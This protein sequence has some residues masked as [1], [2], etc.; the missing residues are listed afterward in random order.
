MQLPRATRRIRDMWS[1]RMTRIMCLHRMY[2]PSLTTKIPGTPVNLEIILSTSKKKNTKSKVEEGNKQ[3]VPGTTIRADL[4][5]ADSALEEYLALTL[6]NGD[7][8]ISLQAFPEA[9][10]ARTLVD[11]IEKVVYQNPLILGFRGYG[12]DY[13]KLTLNVK[14]DDSAETI[15][16][17][18]KEILTEADKVIAAVIKEGMS[19]DEKQMA[20]YDYLNDNTAYDDA[21]LENAKEQEFKTV[22]AKYNDSFNTY[23]I[24]VKKSAYA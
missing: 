13:E 21:A 24:L 23:G 12:Y 11:V 2:R 9:Q 22:D 19:A 15:R 6:I 7:T 3:A 20:I 16:S 8:E 4:I 5:H 18:Q 17:K 14:Y 10:N 1:R